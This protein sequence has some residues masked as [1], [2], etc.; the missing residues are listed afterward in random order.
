MTILGIIKLLLSL[1]N[2]IGEYVKNKQLMDAGASEAMLRGL[3]DANDAITRANVARTT[4]N[5]LPTNLDPNNRD[6]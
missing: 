3:K 6:N 5:S 1:A 4:A 2:T